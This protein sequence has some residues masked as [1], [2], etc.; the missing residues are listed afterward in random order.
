MVALEAAEKLVH[1][2]HRRR[3]CYCPQADIFQSPRALV[4]RQNHHQ[5]AGMSRGRRHRLRGD[6]QPSMLQSAAD[7][8]KGRISI[9]VSV[10]DYAQSNDLREARYPFQGFQVAGQLRLTAD[11]EDLD[12]VQPQMVAEGAEEEFILLAFHDQQLGVL[13]F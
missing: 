11:G 5:H 4:V 2:P 1:A 10:A 7:G 13:Y 12:V 9:L 8:L 6:R 3:S